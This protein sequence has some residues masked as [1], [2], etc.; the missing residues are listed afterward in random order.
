MPLPTPAPPRQAWTA[1]VSRSPHHLWDLYAQLLLSHT[2]DVSV[3]YISQTYH[4][5]LG[6]A[7]YLEDY[8]SDAHLSFGLCRN[9]PV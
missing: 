1:K 6:L 8:P 5:D 4:G 7:I 3:S 9:L 2:V